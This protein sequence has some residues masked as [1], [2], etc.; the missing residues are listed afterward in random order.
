MYNRAYQSKYPLQKAFIL[1]RFSTI[2][3][4]VALLRQRA[5]T[6][7]N[8]IATKAHTIA[9]FGASV[10]TKAWGVATTL[11][12][13][14]FRV[15]MWSVRGALISTGIGAL[16]VGLGLAI[17]YVCSNWESIAP[18]LVAVWEWIKGAI[19][20]IM[21]W[22]SEIFAWIGNGIDTILGGA[23]AVTD[24]LGITDSKASP[25]PSLSTNGL[26]DSTLATQT[27][28]AQ[29]FYN[30]TQSRQINDNKTIYINTTA[31][32]QEV[33]QVIASNSY[34]YAD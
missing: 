12:A 19:S 14:L 27:Q 16:I 1:L 26:V 5:A 30:S 32:A 33:A 10:A 4:S 2:G 6:I 25:S 20:P 23:R 34:S 7:A 17:E 21:D 29:N 28:N 31:S 8:T 11:F 13:K 18:R 22:F 3:A 24:F 9:T 15:S